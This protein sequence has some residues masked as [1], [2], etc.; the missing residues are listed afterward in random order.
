M[1][2]V[3]REPCAP[4]ES[5]QLDPQD[6][7]ERRLLDDAKRRSMKSISVRVFGLVRAI[8]DIKEIFDLFAS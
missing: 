2:D 8:L 5:G 3:Q 4:L 1:K 7:M 6:E